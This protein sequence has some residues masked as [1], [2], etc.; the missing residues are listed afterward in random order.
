MKVDNCKRCK[1]L[2]NKIKTPYCPTCLDEI[3]RQFGLIR[4]Y[5]NE[6]PYADVNT[7]LKETGTEEKVLLFLL[8]EERLTIS[9]RALIPC[10]SCGKMIKSGRYCSECTVK[11]TTEF[12]KAEEEQ[13]KSVKISNDIHQNK[14]SDDSTH[15]R[16]IHILKD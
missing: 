10:D 3:D 16:G 9:T 1:K 5:M 14:K 6:N 4:D 8:R 11:L 7:V 13:K 15:T 12:H 2:Y